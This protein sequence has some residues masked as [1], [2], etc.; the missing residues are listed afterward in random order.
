[1]CSLTNSHMRCYSFISAL[2]CIHTCDKTHSSVTGTTQR[3][4]LLGKKYESVVFVE[5]L[6]CICAMTHSYLCHDSFM[7]IRTS[8]APRY[9]RHDPFVFLASLNG[10]CAMTHSCAFIRHRHCPKVCVTWDMTDS[11]LKNHR[12]LC[13]VS[14]MRICKSQILSKG[15][16]FVKHDSSMCMTW[17]FTCVTWLIRICAIAHS[18]AFVR[19]RRCQKVCATCDFTHPYVW[20]EDVY[21]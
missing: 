10:I 6:I 15:L 19:Y 21:L 13:H 11:Y 2:Q 20:H 5:S 7:R 14:F 16:C 12:Y 18:C 8:Q 4:V 3:S 9:V 17:W 1:M